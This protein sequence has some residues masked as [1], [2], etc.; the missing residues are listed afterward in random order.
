MLDLRGG[1]DRCEVSAVRQIFEI[2]RVRK[3]TRARRDDSRCHL[4]G[5][6]AQLDAPPLAAPSTFA[7]DMSFI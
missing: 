7:I 1:S 3:S 6:N 5:A 4:Q 2:D